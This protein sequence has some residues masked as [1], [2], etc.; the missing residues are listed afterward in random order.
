MELNAITDTLLEATQYSGFFAL[1]TK[2][3]DIRKKT[4][5]IEVNT[6]PGLWF[7]ATT[8]ANCFFVKD[9]YDSLQS[10]F[11][12]DNEPSSLATEAPVVWKYFYKDVFVSLKNQK[13]ISSKVK[14][15]KY[16]NYSYAVYDKKD[17]KPFIF[18]IL[19]GIRKIL[20][21]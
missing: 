3:C 18:D 4:F 13:G 15:P 6:R 20:G 8:S 21:F 14:L 10:N 17:I 19:S 12:L 1:E 5:L 11:P 9:W 16:K 7:G 2:Y